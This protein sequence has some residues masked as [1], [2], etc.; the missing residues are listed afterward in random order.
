MKGFDTNVLVRYLVKDDP[1]QATIVAKLIVEAAETEAPIYLDMIVLCETVWVLESGYDY[2]KDTIA[3]VLEKLLLTQQFELEERDQ[4]WRALR[5][6]RA[7]KGDLADYLIGESNLA[8]D[9][10]RTVTFDRALLEEHG[11]EVLA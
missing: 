6:Y 4:V 2:A 3:D 8:A 5:R 11:F 10:E 7:G 9:C 1:E